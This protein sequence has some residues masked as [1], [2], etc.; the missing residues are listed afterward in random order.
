MVRKKKETIKRRTQLAVFIGCV[1]H[2]N[3]VLLVQRDEPECKDVHLKWELPGGK[4]DWD[5]M[6]EQTVVRELFEETGVKVKIVRLLSHVQINYWDYP[7][8]IQQTI[9]ICYLCQFKSQITFKKKDHHVRQIAW[10]DLKKLSTLE[11]L[12][13]IGIFVSLALKNED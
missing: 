10:V 12:P 11:T 13:G 3:K 1:I 4:I 7:W 2:Q 5:E 8:G 9:I 6:P